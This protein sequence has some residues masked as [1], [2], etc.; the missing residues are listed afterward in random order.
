MHESMITGNASGLHGVLWSNF[1]FSPISEIVLFLQ[2]SF[3]NQ[4]VSFNGYLSLQS[5]WRYAAIR[6]VLVTQNIHSPCVKL[7]VSDPRR[8]LFSKYTLISNCGLKGFHDANRYFNSAVISGKYIFTG[9]AFVQ[10]ISGTG[11]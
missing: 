8:Y 11:Q 1:L 3:S 10:Q 2:E 4:W 6:G 5:I 7:R 9:D